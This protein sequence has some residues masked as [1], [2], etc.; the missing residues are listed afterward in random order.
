MEEMTRAMGTKLALNH[1]NNNG[2][3]KNQGRKMSKNE[4][5]INQ[6]LKTFRSRTESVTSTTSENGQKQPSLY[7]TE[8]CRSFEEQGSCRYGKKCQ[9]AHSL[10]ELRSIQ[11]HPKYKT[12]MCDSFHTSG[13]CPY[14]SRCHFIHNLEEEKS[15]EIEIRK[16]K[17]CHDIGR[18][19]N[20]TNNFLVT[21]FESEW[22][23][24]DSSKPR[25]PE[26]N[27]CS[28]NSV[29][30]SRTSSG[31]IWRNQSEQSFSNFT[32]VGSSASFIDESI[33]DGGLTLGGQPSSFESNFG[34][35][36]MLGGEGLNFDPWE[37][38]R[39]PVFRHL[40]RHD[41]EKA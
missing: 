21:N 11:R 17:S 24:I 1:N 10:K 29:G 5:E 28:L 41:A 7:K 35:P 12:E 15:P 33:W 20:S 19:Q 6:P 2:A 23:K 34:A 26:V 31:S 14:G 37:E 25:S 38:T 22:P 13:Y 40:S 4:I 3:N 9:F 18:T 27:S 32:P 39:L 8:L 30:S 16:N 36:F